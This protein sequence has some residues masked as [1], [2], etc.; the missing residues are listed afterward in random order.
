MARGA[1]LNSDISRCLHIS[2]LSNQQDLIFLWT[3]F[4]AREGQE[5]VQNQG[6]KPLISIAAEG[7]RYQYRSLEKPHT[8]KEGSPKLCDCMLKLE[9]RKSGHRCLFTG[10]NLFRERKQGTFHTW[11][12]SYNIVC[13]LSWPKQLCVV[14]EKLLSNTSKNDWSRHLCFFF[15]LSPPFETSAASIKWERLGKRQEPDWDD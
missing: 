13:F 9:S 2:Q 7:L 8:E 1:K 15:W 11:A 4:D 14:Y 10:S 6:P 3:T 12:S 5:M